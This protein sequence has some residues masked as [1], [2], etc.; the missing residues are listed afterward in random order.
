MH[1]AGSGS[2]PY[3]GHD[4]IRADAT[5]AHGVLAV[6]AQLSAEPGARVAEGGVPWGRRSGTGSTASRPPRFARRGTSLRGQRSRRPRCLTAARMQR[7]RSSVA[8]RRRPRQNSRQELRSQVAPAG[9]ASRLP[10]FV[11]RSVIPWQCRSGRPAGRLSSRSV[12]RVS[13]QETD[14][15][16]LRTVEQSLRGAV[17]VLRDRAAAE[18]ARALRAGRSAEGDRPPASPARWSRAASWSTAT[19]VATRSGSS[20][21]SSARSRERSSTSCT[22]ARPRWT[23]SRRRRARPCCWRSPTGRRSS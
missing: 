19:T 14:G 10:H 7:S 11:S 1:A 21:P 6:P 4:A 8:A 15:H 16:T 13:L 20:S 12:K 3:E 9:S 2:A 18:P 22:R 5:E 23:R 17:C